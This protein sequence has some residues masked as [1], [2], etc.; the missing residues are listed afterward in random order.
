MRKWDPSSTHF[1]TVTQLVCRRLS[2][3]ESRAWIKPMTLVTESEV[4]LKR[5]CQLNSW[6]YGAEAEQGFPASKQG[7]ITLR[8]ASS[9]VGIGCRDWA[10]LQE[11]RSRCS[12]PGGEPT[13]SLQTSEHGTNVFSL[14]MQADQTVPAG[15]GSWWEP[16]KSWTCWLLGPRLGE[17]KARGTRRKTFSSSYKAMVLSDGSSYTYDLGDLNYL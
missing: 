5:P 13:F 8:L 2:L 7:I 14:L 12:T 4:S 6:L 15:P 10:L 3:S 1:P 9:T 11:L 17:R 16:L